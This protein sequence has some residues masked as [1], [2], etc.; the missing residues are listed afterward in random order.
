MITYTCDECKAVFTRGRGRPPKIAICQNCKD[1][2][3]KHEQEVKARKKSS[4][5][6]KKQPTIRKISADLPEEPSVKEP[7][8]GKAVHGATAASVTQPCPECGFAYADGGYCM[9]CGWEKP[10]NRLPAGTATGKKRK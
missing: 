9:D 4:T 2:N 6:P 1:G 3:D 7:E 8:K 5:A 10:I